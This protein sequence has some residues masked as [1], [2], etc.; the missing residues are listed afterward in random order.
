MGFFRMG[1]SFGRDDQFRTTS[2]TGTTLNDLLGAL[3]G[4]GI[5]LVFGIIFVPLGIHYIAQ[6]NADTESLGWIFAILGVIM[7]I[8]GIVLAVALWPERAATPEE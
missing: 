8:I 5:P 3:L 4:G 7:V 2:G 1:R 6:N